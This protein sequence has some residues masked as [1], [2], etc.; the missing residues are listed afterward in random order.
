[1]RFQADRSKRLRLDT[2]RP[3][4]FG[5]S[6]NWDTDQC[7][8][9]G[10]FEMGFSKLKAVFCAD[11]TLFAASWKEVSFLETDFFRSRNPSTRSPMF[12]PSQGSKGTTP[13]RL[14]VQTKP[15]ENARVAKCRL[16]RAL[17]LSYFLQARSY[18]PALK[19]ALP[20]SFLTPAS[21]SFSSAFFRS[22]DSLSFTKLS[23]VTVYSTVE[24][25]QR[26]T[27]WVG[28][29][30]VFGVGQHVGIKQMVF[31]RHATTWQSSLRRCRGIL[32]G[33]R[34]RGTHVS[35]QERTTRG[36]PS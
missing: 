14:H 8:Q 20:A 2:G 26:S 4:S 16:H 27:Y 34:T 3:D 21:A 10:S 17:T 1:M 28:L 30:D 22:H 15:P 11:F 32:H 25:A 33:E 35:I 23:S 7:R 29:A 18:L 19:S 5:G 6:I 24:P 13:K 36:R 9:L 31:I 12:L